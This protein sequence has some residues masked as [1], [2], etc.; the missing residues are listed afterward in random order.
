MP[1]D[2]P[3]DFDAIVLGAGTGGEH[4]AARLHAAGKRVALIERELIGGECAYWACI[5]SKT[6]L[7]PIKVAHE[8]DATPSL[9]APPLDVGAA[10][11]FRDTAI[12]HLNDDKQV[13]AYAEQGMTFL[14]GTARI[15]AAGRVVI[16]GP[17]PR[18]LAAPHIILAT[19]SDV[20]VPQVDGLAD[21]GYWTNREAT[22]FHETPRSVV[23][24]GADAQAVELAQMVRGFGAAVTIVSHDERLLH[25]EDAVVSA[26]LLE[27]C[28]AVGIAMRL[29][30]TV[31]RVARVSADHRSL[32]L[33]DGA[34]IAAEQVL[35]ASGRAPRV[36]GLGLEALGVRIGKRG[37]IV[38]EH[39]RAAPGIWAVGDV[40]GVALFTHVAQ[41][42]GR[43]AADDILG[44]SHAADYRAIPRV[45][46]CTPE[47]ASTGLTAEQAR[48]QDIDVAVAT[49]DLA[50][51]IAAPSTYG[52]RVRARLSLIADRARRTLV[53]A[54]V[55]GP[56]AGELIHLAVL[57]IRANISIDVL[58]DTM[59]QF[60]TMSEGYLHAC[61]A[62]DI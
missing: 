49:I 11:A 21:A 55:V 16:D 46:F 3:D 37:I 51:A 35:V 14:R 47:V 53:G 22:T 27:H 58:R 10:L 62:L 36:Q 13:R 4:A 12:Q 48:Q 41:Y 61:D 38:D 42:Q 15:E 9:S 50:E 52:P 6:L 39:C 29:G 34:T 43:I 18:R 1:T 26:L 28:T 24:L 54:W 60:P 40:T 19:G 56:A 44:R 32:T 25:R 33:D 30:R 31:A 7:H 5:P 45:V 8:A 23:V 2:T 57:A 17:A 59:Y 20:R